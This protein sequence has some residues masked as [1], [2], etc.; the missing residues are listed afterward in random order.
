[1]PEVVKGLVIRETLAGEY[2]KLLT[3]LTETRGKLFFRAYGVRSLINRNSASC[4]IF[5]Y[6]EFVLREKND[7]YYLSQAQLIKSSLEPG[8]EFDG[9]SLAFYFF[10]LCDYCASDEETCGGMLKMLMNALYIISKGDRPYDLIKA[11]FELRLMTLLG[12]MP[13]MAGCSLCGRDCGVMDEKSAFH[14]TNGNLRCRDCA[15]KAARIEI[16]DI[17]N[18]GEAIKADDIDSHIVYISPEC[19]RLVTRT[20][21]VSENTAYAV[22]V[23]MTLL[24]EFSAFAERYTVNQLE[25]TFD[26]LK[27]YKDFKQ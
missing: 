21:S 22:N 2:D 4:R 12:F 13:D 1:M 23:P 18:E 6:S 7:H 26:T 14:L 10:D 9:M 5:S 19:V 8:T 17:I 16:E 24:K 11:V 27:F 15:A 25:R 20:I 3:V